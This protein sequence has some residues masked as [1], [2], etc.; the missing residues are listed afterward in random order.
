METDLTTSLLEPLAQ[1]LPLPRAL[2]DLSRRHPAV[3][4][5]PDPIR[6]RMQ[7][8][9]DVLNPKWLDADVT[10][11]KPGHEFTEKLCVPADGW[12]LAVSTSM[13]WVMVLRR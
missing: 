9:V 2:A 6:Q 12:S 3:H 8:K 11:L 7:F 5:L 10:D 1:L 4:P 13:C